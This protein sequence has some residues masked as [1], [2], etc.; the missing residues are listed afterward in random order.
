MNTSFERV[1]NG[2]EEWLTPKYIIDA[3]GE[4]DLDPCSPIHRPWDTAKKYYT[5]KEDGLSQDWKGRVFMNPPYGNKTGEWLKKLSEYGNGIAL[6]FA[7][8]E[9][10]NFFEYIW[11]KATAILFLKG[12]I[13]F[14]N[15]DGTLGNNSAGAPSCLIAYGYNNAIALRCSDLIGKYILLKGFK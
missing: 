10:K 4:F 11:P 3:L 14:Y 13:K 7:R 9:T 6:I 2:K 15:V 12:R 5:I 8:T 1:K